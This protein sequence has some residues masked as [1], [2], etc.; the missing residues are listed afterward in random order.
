MKKLLSGLLIAVMMLQLVGCGKTEQPT[1]ETPDEKKVVE[2]KK[3]ETKKE[4]TKKD[5]PVKKKE[6]ETFSLV[7]FT[8]WYKAGWEAVIAD[9]ENRQE[10]LG[11][12]L[13]VEQI[14][15]TQG[16]QIIQTRFAAGEMP[17]FFEYYTA[18]DV[19]KDLGGGDA[20][21]SIEGDWIK[22]Y[23]EDIIKSR[24]YSIDGKVV[25]IPIDPVVLVGTFYN[26][27][28]FEELN[29]EVPTTWDELLAVCETIKAAGKV[30][31]HYPGKEP[32]A[33][34][35][36]L[37]EGFLREYEDSSQEDF[38][39]KINTKQ[40]MF[41][42]LDMVKDALVKSKE[43][44][45]KGYVQETF[46]SDTYDMQQKALAKGEVAMIF[47]GTWVID[48]INGKYPEDVNNIGAFAIPFDGTDKSSQF[49]PFSFF[50]TAGNKNPELGQK[51]IEY[52]TST[53]TQQIFA[54][55]QPGLWANK[56]VESDLLPAVKDMK[57]WMDQDMTKGWFGYFFK[58]SGPTFDVYIQDYYAG[59]REVEGI[60]EEAD[61]EYARNAQSNGDENWK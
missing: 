46:L 33:L 35:M 32:W 44:I 1:S 16:K 22:N 43:L 26:K 18:A 9:I 40:T 47:Q 45:D 36:M 50:M 11:F 48:E 19:V 13:E 25:G 55:A 14:S 24:F 20:V 5:E 6:V 54:T 7:M 49:V 51:V 61:N 30:P 17:D 29:L 10:E 53:E 2:T 15:G 27:A 12:N 37:N 31:F 34:T 52:L 57:K 38:F 23:S 56:T 42:D 28:I 60:L 59:G 41:Q 3:E 8:D 58:H 39:E 4:E 21:L